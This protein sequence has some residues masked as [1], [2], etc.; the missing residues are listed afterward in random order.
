MG[1]VIAPIVGGIPYW[2]I[3][4]YVPD[5]FIVACLSVVLLAIGGI[6]KLKTGEIHKIKA[7]EIEM[8]LL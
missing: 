5:L 8:R 2:V 7:E 4:D 1:I 3:K 6:L